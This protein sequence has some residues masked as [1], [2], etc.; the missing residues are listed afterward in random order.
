MESASAKGI[1]RAPVREYQRISS[2]RALS[3]AAVPSSFTPRR[4]R[5]F[6]R[7]ST[8]ESRGIFSRTKAAESS[9]GGMPQ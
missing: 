3:T 7:M 5:A 2:F 4:P 6:L 1:S 8:A 9:A